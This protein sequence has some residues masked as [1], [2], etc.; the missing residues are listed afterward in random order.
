[1]KKMPFTQFDFELYSTQKAQDLIGKSD[2]KIIYTETQTEK[3]KS[4]TGELVDRSF[5]T[6]VLEKS[7]K[8]F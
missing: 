2:F 8:S 6:F 7:F 3:V 4:K 1:M 5:T